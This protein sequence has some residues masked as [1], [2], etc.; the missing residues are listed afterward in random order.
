MN[1]SLTRPHQDP[2]Y[3]FEFRFKS[4]KAVVFNTRQFFDRVQSKNPSPV[5]FKLPK[6]KDC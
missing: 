5:S 6:Y 1:I 4:K 2:K 3:I